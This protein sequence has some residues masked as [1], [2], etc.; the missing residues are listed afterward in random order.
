MIAGLVPFCGAGN[1]LPLIVP[2]LP[3]KKA[4][5]AKAL[6]DYRDAMPLLVSNLNA[7]IFDYV[8]R[9]KVQ[10]THL[11]WYIVRKKT[12]S[13]VPPDDYFTAFGPKAARDIVREEVLALSY[14]AHDMAPF[15]RDMGHIDPLTGEVKSPFRFDQRDRL[16]PPRKARCSLF[17]AVLSKCHVAG[18]RSLRDT[19]GYIYSTFPILEREE[20]VTYGRYMSR[21]LCLLYI[22]ALA[23]GDPDVTISI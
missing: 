20:K 2:D 22:N 19:I 10:S 1:T 3:D 13:V 9:Q 6:N 11:N 15:A 7:L 14:T 18:R 5:R 17:H 4:A 8:A 16:P 12:A 21:D 23:A